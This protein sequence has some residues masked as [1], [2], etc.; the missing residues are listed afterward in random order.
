MTEN[1]TVKA[2]VFELDFLR[3]LALLMMVLHHLI[4]DLR[5]L[6]KLDVLLFRRHGV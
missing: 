4:Y 3:G 6:L 2:R 5:F 1:K